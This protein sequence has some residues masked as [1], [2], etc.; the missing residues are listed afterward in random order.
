MP[1]YENGNWRMKNN[2][3]IYEKLKSPDI[4]TVIKVRILECFGEL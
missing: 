3:V 1:T 2:Q 4:L